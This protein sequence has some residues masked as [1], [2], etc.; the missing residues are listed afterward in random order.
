MDLSK[1]TAVELSKLIADTIASGDKD[2]SKQFA[3]RDLSDQLGLTFGSDGMCR[4]LRDRSIFNRRHR[5]IIA[6]Y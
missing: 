5:A 1:Y 3:P 4:H 6:L 2:K